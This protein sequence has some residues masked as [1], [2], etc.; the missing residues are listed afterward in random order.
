MV[1]AFPF[2]QDFMVLRDAMNQLLEDSFVPARGA[3]GTNGTMV[4]PLPLDV[5]ATQDEVVIIAATPGMDPQALEVTVNQ[6]VVTLSGTVPTATESEQGKGA[7]WY[8]HELWHG[9][10][11]RSVTL[12]FEVDSARAEAT[13][14]HGIVRITLPKAERAKPFRIA[15][16]G[17]EGQREAI[18]AGSKAKQ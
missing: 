17:G 6:N 4:R 18:E 10:F 8:L 15:I 3:R 1:S 2:G 14:E 16:K 12:P 7:T 9:Q 5:Y 13:F 11:R